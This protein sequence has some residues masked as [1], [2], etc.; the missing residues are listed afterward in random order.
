MEIKTIN[1][2]LYFQIKNNADK[3]TGKE[4]VCRVKNLCGEGMRSCPS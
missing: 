3:G 4:K 1:R 2:G